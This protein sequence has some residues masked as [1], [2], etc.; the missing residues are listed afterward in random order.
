MKFE[1]SGSSVLGKSRF[2]QKW[3]ITMSH[4]FFTLWNK[5][6]CIVLDVITTWDVKAW[7]YH[8]HDNQKVFWDDRSIRSKRY[9][10]QVVD[11]K[12]ASRNRFNVFLMKIV[13][14]HL[15]KTGGT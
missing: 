11:I 10:Y 8:G 14:H 6:C 9:P 4:D 15:F 5:F 12:P 1:E 7:P 3:S 2:D 13:V